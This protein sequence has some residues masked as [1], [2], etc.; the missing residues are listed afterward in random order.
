MKRR[1]F[2]AAAAG[3]LAAPNVSRAQ[4]RS[5]LKIIPEGDLAIVDP[6]F[7]T[8][9]VARNHGYA[10]FDTLYGQD[11]SYAMRPQMVAGHVVENDG[12]QWTL[13]LRDGLKFHDGEP[14]RGRDCVASIRRFSARDAFG[15]AL[16]AA[17]EEVSAPDDR[18]IRFRLNKAFP[19]LPNALGKTGTPMPCIMPERLA[20]TDPNKQVTEMV[21][22]GP[23]R[24]VTAERVPGSRVVYEKFAGYV[25]RADGPATFT[26][27]PKVAHFERVEWQVIPDSSTAASA[28]MNGEVDWIQNPSVDL[29]PALRGNARLQFL[30]DVIG[31]ISVMRFN[32]IQP[33]FDNPALRRALLGA[34]DQ[35]EF[36]TASMGDDRSLWKDRVG[37]F[38]PGTPMASEA[39]L[40][41]LLGKRDMAKVKADIAAS[42]YKG[43]RVVML[44]A[45]DYPAANA[46]SLVGVDLFNKLGLNVDF[47]AVDWGTT[48]QRRAKKDPV[49]K[50]GWSVFF[51]DLTGTNNFDPAANLGLRANGD[52]AWFGW[53]DNPKIEALRAA[54]FDARG[55]DEQK[56][57][58]A[59]LQVEFMRAPA[60]LVLG[61]NYGPTAFSK[62]ITGVRMGFPQFYDVRRV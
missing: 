37:L 5:V 49:D 1:S 52:K 47:Q 56:R 38:T 28:L 54:W 25:P 60:H 40:E 61:C 32:C 43:E 15:Q 41:P 31:G 35:A 4:G 13:T 18:T 2:L 48:I 11:D 26:A 46:R 12:K 36:M 45:V 33:P 58:C 55:L 14:V 9:T 50:G 59:E 10:V 16:M 27:G 42:G 30:P 62:G 7:T 6:V 53:P 22:S 29:L 8:A 21:G 57:I 17:T 44:G 51:T 34:V 3:A 39:G 24:F 19:L 23:Y 20:Q